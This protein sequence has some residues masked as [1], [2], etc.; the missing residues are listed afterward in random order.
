MYIIFSDDLTEFNHRV[1][2]PE[3][4]SIEESSPKNDDSEEDDLEKVAPTVDN[5]EVDASEGGASEGDAPEPDAPR[6]ND[7]A[8][9]VEGVGLETAIHRVSISFHFF[10]ISS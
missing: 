7:E 2:R 9:I 5:S 3:I 8:D 4:E 10:F 1:W 6:E